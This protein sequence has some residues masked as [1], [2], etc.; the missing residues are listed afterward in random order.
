MDVGGERMGHCAYTPCSCNPQAFELD[1]LVALAD[2]WH[3][4]DGRL[5]LATPCILPAG[6]LDQLLEPL[7]PAGAPLCKLALWGVAPPHAAIQSSSRI[8]PL[9]LLNIPQSSP[10]LLK[11][12]PSV[13]PNLTS[14]CLTGWDSTSNL[15][16]GQLPSM[17]ALRELQLSRCIDTSGGS[18]IDAWMPAL[19][20]GA[21]QLTLLDVAGG[22]SNE[23]YEVL[24]S[25]PA[26]TRPSWSPAQPIQPLL[27]APAW[28]AGMQGV[29]SLTLAHNFLA[30]LPAAPYLQSE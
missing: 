6:S 27:A 16:P 18:A 5:V 8:V 9:D 29:R 13:L 24:C 14:L 15:Q 4:T 26:N 3:G 10:S 11:A 7:L 21:S 19:L 22:M 28:L 1:G 25:D 30:D 20:A 12:L 23:T 17:P 2:N